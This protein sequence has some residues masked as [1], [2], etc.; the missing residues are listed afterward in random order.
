MGEALRIVAVHEALTTSAMPDDALF[1]RMAREGYQAVVSLAEPIDIRYRPDEDAIVTG[2][3][4]RYFHIPVDFE[5]P[6][7]ADYEWLRDVLNALFPRKV[8]LHCAQNKR[9]SGMMYLY[10]VLERGMDPRTARALM[11]SIWQPDTAW[12]TLFAAVMEKHAYQYL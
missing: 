5:H 10:N 3:G 6:K 4:M 2:L 7:V 11:E 12:E 1:A 9:V 8:W